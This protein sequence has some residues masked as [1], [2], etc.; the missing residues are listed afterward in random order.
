MEVNYKFITEKMKREFMNTLKTKEEPR[1]SEKI[2]IT[3][4]KAEKEEEVE[5]DLKS[6][7]KSKNPRKKKHLQNDYS[8]CYYDNNYS[9]PIQHFSHEL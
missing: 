3:H 8:A 1:K 7:K 9:Q 5:E 2:I 6:Q 4:Q